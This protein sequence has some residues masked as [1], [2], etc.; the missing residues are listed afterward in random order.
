MGE[1]IEY[2]KWFF[3][4]FALIVI[5]VVISIFIGLGLK[6]TVGVENVNIDR[7]IYEQSKSYIHGKTQDLAKY[8]EEYQSTDEDGKQVIRNLIQMNFTEFDETKI[9]NRRLRIFL[10]EMRGY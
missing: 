8:Y 1:K 2:S 7:E 3:L 10:Q 9:E 5:V 4:I 6:K